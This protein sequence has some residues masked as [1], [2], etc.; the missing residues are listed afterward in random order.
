MNKIYY[1]Q[2]Q[3]G[4]PVLQTVAKDYDS[5]LKFFSEYLG[6]E[7]DWLLPF[8]VIDKR[9]YDAAMFLYN[10]RQASIKSGF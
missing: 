7:N 8:H 10:K 5:A 2:N 6:I 3:N 9:D 1:W 4:T